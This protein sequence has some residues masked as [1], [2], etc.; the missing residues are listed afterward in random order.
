ML[1]QR[2]ISALWGIP[3]V[4]AAIWFGDPWF[5]ILVAVIAIL[6]AFEFYEMISSRV[7]PWTFFGLIW[8]V[9]MV[10]SP[11]SDD[12]RVVPLLFTS[13][14][15][16]SLDW[17]V[18]RPT[19]DAFSGWVWTLA[20]I[21]Y[22]GWMLSHLVGLRRL[23]NGRDWV[24]LVIFA[25]FATDSVAYLLGRAFGRHLMA[26][27]ISPGKTWEGAV[28]GLAGGLAATVALAFILDLTPH[29]LSYPGVVLLGFLIPV[30]AQLGD[31]AESLLKRSA[32]VKD[33]GH[34]I[35]GH[36]GMLDR[37]DSIIFSSIIVYYYVIWVIG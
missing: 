15:V 28:A 22:V 10:L 12:D 24:L 23:D 14:V 32:G 1:K 35:P 30:F 2:I 5:S 27:A 7:S 34:L 3:L 17:F 20:G 6:A 31:L 25:T 21:F 16:I 8:V 18:W 19:R 29:P 4:F 13:A 9:L 37:M 33:A 36:G 11:H 26:P